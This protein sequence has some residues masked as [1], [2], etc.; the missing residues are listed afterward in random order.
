M[1]LLIDSETRT[2]N[3]EPIDGLFAPEE[4]ELIKSIPL[5]CGSAE[6]VIFWPHSSNGRYSCK[7]G[8][9]FLKEEADLIS[10]GEPENTKLW[11]GIWALN[12]PNKIKNIM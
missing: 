10:S 7:T 2:W 8:Y 9:H 1:D 6:D 5:A 4:A 12:C 3:V 11:K